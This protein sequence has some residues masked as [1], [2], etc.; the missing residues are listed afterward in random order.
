M[1]KILLFV[2]IVSLVLY[3]QNP[4]GYTEVSEKECKSESWYTYW[5]LGLP[6]LSLRTSRHY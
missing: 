3:G 2:F 6:I 5:G 4:S 1:K